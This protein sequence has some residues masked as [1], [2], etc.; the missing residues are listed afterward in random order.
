MTPSAVAGVFRDARDVG[1]VIQA[2]AIS[3][4]GTTEPNAIDRAT[5]VA[6]EALAQR[7]DI[8]ASAGSMTVLMNGE[9]AGVIVAQPLGAP[10]LKELGEALLQ[11]LGTHFGGAQIAVGMAST[12]LHKELELDD[13]LAV[14][15][16]GLE[17]ASLSRSN[18]AVH[19]ELYELILATRRRHGTVYPLESVRHDDAVHEMADFLPRPTQDLPRAEE[20]QAEFVPAETERNGRPEVLSE[21]DD[22]FA[23]LASEAY[24]LNV[25]SAMALT[26][27]IAP[28]AEAVAQLEEDSRV[29]IER[30]R[31]ELDVARREKLELKGGSDAAVNI[32]ERRINKLVHQLEDAEVEIERLRREDDKGVGSVYRSVQGLDPK[33]AKAPTRRVLIDG[34]FEANRPED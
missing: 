18:R 8:D 24:E 31:M 27:G 19:S 11:T 26:N 13:V 1:R 12:E 10:A 3:V 32:Q 21:L 33:E 16:E 7:A 4:S 2:F 28:R 25:D 29:E 20:T 6:V 14:A 15:M 5:L 34:V 23:H 30:L 9:M 22:P 17:V